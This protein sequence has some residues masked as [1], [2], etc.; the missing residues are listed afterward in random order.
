M[1]VQ[2]YGAHDRDVSKDPAVRTFEQMKTNFPH[3]VCPYMVAK[4]AILVRRSVDRGD[5]PAIFNVQLCIHNCVGIDIQGARRICRFCD[6][7]CLTFTGVPYTP[8]TGVEFVVIGCSKMN[9]HGIFADQSARQTSARATSFAT[10]ASS[11][12]RLLPAT[13]NFSGGS[14]S[15]D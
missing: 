11:G 10:T 12:C 8:A 4:C 9:S 3:S 13:K 7:D 14:A 5:E 15:L 6:L 1:S 2:T